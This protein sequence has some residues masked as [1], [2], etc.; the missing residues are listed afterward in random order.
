MNGANGFMPP[1]AGIPNAAR[2]PAQAPVAPAPKGSSA[3]GTMRPRY[4]LEV[5][6]ARPAEIIVALDDDAPR[7]LR[8]EPLRA[9]SKGATIDGVEIAGRGSGG[10]LRVKVH[11]LASLA[12]GRYTG[13]VMDAK[14]G[15][16]VG[17][18][19]VVLRGR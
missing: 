17:R 10:P 18:L 14:T 15:A 16:A 4:V 6:S 7:E 8:V 1:A 5:K 13:A 12:A 9:R 2:A 19:T 3:S 11:V